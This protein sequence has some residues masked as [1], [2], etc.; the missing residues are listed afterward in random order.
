MSIAANF[1]AEAIKHM[2]W[3]QAF[4]QDQ[5]LPVQVSGNFM[6][7][8]QLSGDVGI[9]DSKELVPREG[10]SQRNL[11]APGDSVE[12]KPVEVTSNSFNITRKI[13]ESYK[14]TDQNR[15]QIED[16][17]TQRMGEAPTVQDIA[18][19][20][21]TKIAAQV[22]H[23]YTELWRNDLTNTANWQSRDL[24]SQNEQFNTSGGETAF[25]DNIERALDSV[26]DREVTFVISPPVARA[27]QGYDAIQS[28]AG[29]PTSVTEQRVD[30]AAI[31]SI[32]TDIY[33]ELDDVIVASGHWG[34]TSNWSQSTDTI[35][36]L[37]DDT[38]VMV[39]RQA[40]MNLEQENEEPEAEA[41]R[42]A[43]R[44]TEIWYGTRTWEPHFVNDD[45]LAF[46]FENPIN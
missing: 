10:D 16:V 45:R 24:N 35:D 29:L 26:L 1:S 43:G 25:F 36:R 38:A 3:E 21:A 18:E 46:V 9:L 40:L 31:S 20:V 32:L 34:L 12:S 23:R 30:R 14:I 19:W 33:P 5:M 22:E 11:A 42:P 2:I 17:L 7:V 13:Q 44:G 39:T 4:S 41:E 8:S 27:I 37:F 28:H 15:A 6:P